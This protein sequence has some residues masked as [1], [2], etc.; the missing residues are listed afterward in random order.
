M[1][2]RSVVGERAVNDSDSVG[3]DWRAGNGE[4][5]RTDWGELEATGIVGVLARHQLAVANEDSSDR[6]VG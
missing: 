4:P 1:T 5:V 2:D 3:D 6:S